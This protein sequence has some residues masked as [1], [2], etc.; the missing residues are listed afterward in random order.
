MS[1]IEDRQQAKWDAEQQDCD[2]ARHC[3]MLT[4][5]CEQV[6][7]PIATSH[8]TTPTTL[9]IAPAQHATSTQASKTPQQLGPDNAVFLTFSFAYTI[10]HLCYFTSRS[11]DSV[12][13]STHLALDG[14]L[15]PHHGRVPLPP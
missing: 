8:Q 5:K 10:I 12:G 13:N 14:L 2:K 3:K 9:P 11:V 7:K 15:V 4:A 1:T 6:V